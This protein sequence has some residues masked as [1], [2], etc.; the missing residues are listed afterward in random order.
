MS[1]RT[2]II[3]V[4]LPNQTIIHVEATVVSGE[5]DVAAMPALPFQ[6]ML[7][8]IEGIAQAITATIHR[9]SPRKAKV[10]LGLEVG[11]EAGHLTALLVKGTGTASLK[12][13]LEWGGDTQPPQS[14]PE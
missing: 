1:V 9:V 11:V 7:G 6:E 13:T 4:K 5:Q 12:I 2:E 10:E 3:P 8:A 14:H